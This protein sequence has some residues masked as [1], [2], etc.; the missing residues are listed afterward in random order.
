[1]D[2]PV[3]E[4]IL[5]MVSPAVMISACG[6]MLLTLGNKYSRVVDRIRAFTA[7]LRAL[8]ARDGQL[9][10]AD[11][12]R[13]RILD[14]ELPDL[15]RR[16]RLVRNAILEFYTAVGLFVICSFFIPLTHLGVPN[17]APLTLFCL[18]MVSV[19]VATITAWRE[20]SLSFRMLNLERRE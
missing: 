19:L 16:G 1:M 4:F 8:K 14:L 11:A 15:F 7:E 6:L 2:T 5:Q 12:A 20:T 13:K 17:W 18:G 9:S 3:I 10:M